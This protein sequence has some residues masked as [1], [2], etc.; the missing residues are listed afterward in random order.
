MPRSQRLSELFTAKVY[1]CSPGYG[2]ECNTVELRTTFSN[3]HMRDLIS[4]RYQAHS[5]EGGTLY[6]AECPVTNLIE[7][8]THCPGNQ[9]GFGGSVFNITMLDGSERSIKGP[10]SGA[11][12]TNSKRLGLCGTPDLLMEVIAIGP[13]GYR[14]GRYMRAKHIKH[15][16]GDHA[17]AQLGYCKDVCRKSES[18]ENDRFGRFIDWTL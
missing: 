15:L 16:L 11:C 13:E 12:T 10:W 18:L 7:F 14:I 9:S 2:N 6:I 4:F 17:W 5:V 8:F 1:N 3:L